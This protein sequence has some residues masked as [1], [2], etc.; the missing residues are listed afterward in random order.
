MRENVRV[1]TRNTRS[2]K[3]VARG[4]PRGGRVFG[5]TFASPRTCRRKPLVTSAV[6]IRERALRAFPSGPPT[7]GPG[8]A[9]THHVD[10]ALLVESPLLVLVDAPVDGGLHRRTGERTRDAERGH[11]DRSRHAARSRKTR[12]SPR[13]RAEGGLGARVVSFIRDTARPLSVSADPQTESTDPGLLDRGFESFR[14]DS[15]DDASVLSPSAPRTPARAPP[16]SPPRASALEVRPEPPTEVR[17]SV[18][19]RLRPGRPAVRAE[20]PRE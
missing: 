13:A 4:C 8:I 19:G 1:T 5:F 11:A 20:T 6:V 16:R 7:A 17:R 3:I 10:F 15:R 2:W 12:A 9:R 18:R 14:K